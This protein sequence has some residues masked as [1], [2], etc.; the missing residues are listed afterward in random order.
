VF[1]PDGTVRD[2]SIVAA[3]F[4]FFRNRGKNVV[5]DVPDR[6]NHLTEAVTKNKRWLAD[7]NP[8]WE[9][10][11]DMAEVSANL[12]EAAQLTPMHILPSRQVIL[13]R[14]GQP[15][16]PALRALLEK[17]TAILEPYEL[18]PGDPRRPRPPGL[19]P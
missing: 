11:L 4:G 2:P 1:Y 8:D 17:F 14:N 5:E 19:M 6:E 3:L 15:D 13:L 12:L 10:G 18:P 9:T 7:P 16:M